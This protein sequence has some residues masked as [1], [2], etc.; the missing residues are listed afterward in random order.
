MRTMHVGPVLHHMLM[1][2]TTQ[3][4]VTTEL[5]GLSKAQSLSQKVIASWGVCI[6]LVGTRAMLFMCITDGRGQQVSNISNSL[7]R[8]SRVYFRCDSFDQEIQ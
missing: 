8:I 5:M 4:C 1:N 7:V 3:Q 2:L 6:L